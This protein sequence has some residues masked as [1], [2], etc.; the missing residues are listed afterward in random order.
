[1]KFMTNS[2]LDGYT[3]QLDTANEPTKANLGREMLQG[4]RMLSVVGE[5][6]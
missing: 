2:F 4:G 6:N 5:L 3:E 1:M